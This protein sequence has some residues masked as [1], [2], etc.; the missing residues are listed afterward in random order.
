MS[1]N[2]VL[3][4]YKMGLYLLIDPI[5]V[6]QPC[7]ELLGELFLF[8]I[9]LNVLVILVYLNSKIGFFFLNSFIFVSQS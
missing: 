1:V 7:I 3:F 5:F 4:S 8:Q 9:P 2:L 6:S